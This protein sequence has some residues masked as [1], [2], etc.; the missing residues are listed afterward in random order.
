MR[1]AFSLVECLVVMSVVALL[2]GIALPLLGH[3]R[4]TAT[5]LKC[6]SHLRTCGQAFE[7]YTA[8]YSQCLPF[9]AR[10]TAGAAFSNGGIPIGYTLQTLHWPV[11]LRGYLSENQAEPARLCPANPLARELFG[12]GGGYEEFFST[13]SSSYMLP[14]DY[15]M[16]YAAITDPSTWRPGGDINDPR[17]YRPVFVSEVV[18]PSRKGLLLEPRAFHLGG[19]AF[20][21]GTATV[22]IFYELGWDKP[23]H[24]SFADGHCENVRYSDLTPGFGGNGLGSM[25]AAPVLA[26]PDGV[27]GVDIR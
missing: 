1:R 25:R 21:R 7:A 10:R 11:A 20:D 8:D 4:R 9:F 23:Y 18:F 6:L 26:T 19:E 24:V 27:R 15:W 16:T 22:S 12:A 5:A 14:A 2:L 13:L 3:A 17:F